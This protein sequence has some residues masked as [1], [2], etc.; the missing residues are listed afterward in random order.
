MK[1]IYFILF[2]IFSINLTFGQATTPFTCDGNGYLFLNGPADVY[3]VNLQTGAAT[4]VK[5]DIIPNQISV[6]YNPVDNYIWGVDK[7][8]KQLVKIDKNWNKTLYNTNLPTQIH[9]ADIDKNGIF[10][11]YTGTQIYRYNLNTTP[12]TQLS[13]LSTTSISVSDFAFNPLDGF[14]YGVTGAGQIYKINPANG[15]TTLVRTISGLVNQTY[16]AAYFDA[17][18]TLYLS[19]NTNGKVYKISN[20]ALTNPSSTESAVFFSNGPTASAND[21]ARCAFAPLCKVGAVAP[22][23]SQSSITNTCTS[24]SVSLAGISASNTPDGTSL[25]WHSG[26]PTTTA[27]KLSNLTITT[28]GTYYATFFDATNNCYSASNTPFVVT[29]NPVPTTPTSVAASSTSICSGASVNLTG[30]CSVGTLTWY[31][32]SPSGTLAGTGSPKAVTLT[33]TKT[34]VATCKTTSPACES[35]PS[36]PITITV[37]PKPNPPTIVAGS[38]RI[39]SGTSTTLTAQDCA[40]TVNWSTGATGPSI[41]VSPTIATSY[42]A[43]CT[44]AAGCVSNASTS[45]INITIATVY[46]SVDRLNV[47]SGESVT[48][49]MGGCAT[50]RD[51]YGNAVLISSSG[52]SNTFVNSPLTNTTYTAKCGAT[53]ATSCATNSTTGVAVTVR[54]TPSAPTTSGTTTICLGSSATLT[55][56]GCTGTVNWSDSQTG[57]SIT[58][59]PNSTTSYTATCNTNGC[60]SPVS[61]PVIVTVE[62]IPT[63]PTGLNPVTICLNES[64]NLGG[65]C[66]ANNLRWYSNVGLTI[67]ETMPVAPTSTKTYYAICRSTNCQSAAIPVVVTVNPIPT[68]PTSLVANPATICQGKS[69]VMSGTCAV[70]SNLVWYSDLGLTSVLVSSTVSPNST[71]TYYASCEKSGCKSPASQITINVNPSPTDPTSLTSSTSICTG[72]SINLTGTCPSGSTIQWYQGVVDASSLKGTGSPFAVSPTETTTYV[73]TCKSNSN[74]C[75]SPSSANI[76]INLT[77]TPTT[78]TGVSVSKSQICSGESVTL[79]GTCSTGTIKWYINAGLTNEVSSPDSP[80]AT[81]T[82]YGSCVIGACKSPSSNVTVSV[83]ATPSIPTSLGATNPIICAGQ[84]STLSGS[85]TSGTLTWYSNIGLTSSVGSTVQPNSTSTYYASCVN[86][87]CKSPAASIEI[88]VVSI[89]NAP[90]STSNSPSNVCSGQTVSLNG[91]CS[92]TDGIHW[93][94][95]SILTTEITPS[96]LTPNSTTTY[97]AVC[98]NS[99]C[100]SSTTSH[101]VQVNALPAAPE[102]VPSSRNLC[103]GS[104]I[105]MTAS[106]C[107]GTVNWTINGVAGPSTA[108]IIQT[109]T[110]TSTYTAT[111]TNTATNCVSPASGASVVTV[112][113]PPPTPSISISKNVICEGESIVLTS[114]NCTGIT[115]WFRTGDITSLSTSNPLTVTPAS[116]GSYYA[117]CSTSGTVIQCES[118]SSDPLPVTVNPLPIAPVIST[119]DNS[120]CAGESTDLTAASCAGTVN[121]SNGQTGST[122]TVSPASTTLYTAKCMVSNCEGPVSNQITITVTNIPTAPTS[123]SATSICSGQFSTLSGTCAS[124]TI[125]WFSDAA[126][127]IT[128]SSSVNPSTTKTYYAKCVDV[129]CSGPSSSVVVTVVQTPTAPSGTSSNPAAICSGS[130]AE[131]LGACATG[132]LKWYPDNTLNTAL[133]SNIVAP[134]SSTSYFASCENGSCK[135][136][137]T[138]QIVNVNAI[139]AVPILTAGANS[140]CATASTVLTAS[141]CV[142]TVIWSTLD[143][144]STLTVSPNSNTTY[145]ATCTDA[146]GCISPSSASLNITVI[147]TPEAPTITP[148]NSEI[149]PGETVNLSASGC[150][151]T[152]NW[153]NSTSPTTIVSTG[154][155]LSVTPAISSGYFTKCTTTLGSCVSSESE[156]AVVTVKAIPTITDILTP[157]CTD[158]SKSLLAFQTSGGATSSVSSTNGLT[159]TFDSDGR[160]TLS[161]QDSRQVWVIENIP[162]TTSF[163]VTVI[164]NGCQLTKNYSSTDC[165]TASVF[166]VD[167]LWFKGMAQSENIKLD[168]YVSNEVNID[169]FE[170]ERSINAIDFSK[171]GTTKA[172]NGSENHLYTYVDFSPFSGINYYRLKNIEFDGKSKYSKTIAVNFTERFDFQWNIFPNPVSKDQTGITLKTNNQA[173]IKEINIS[174]IQGIRLM[175]NVSKISEN[176]HFVNFGKLN[177]GVYLMQIITTK[178][179]DTKKFIIQK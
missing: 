94:S 1:K 63:T 16:G 125:Q 120:I 25:T 179:T 127:T 38:T 169:K 130:T 66:G 158:N 140:I 8:T 9:V 139:P 177:P 118:G 53:N 148:G 29:I 52:S 167:I 60:I 32:N 45:T 21:G 122:L 132:I 88:N 178:G 64:V 145:T 19:G 47:C 42:T 146:N 109:P 50:T 36:S 160:E 110:I 135:S 175:S 77:S 104:T 70:G 91:T 149:C 111:C 57:S 107:A 117:T 166:P 87:A 168:W 37:N 71:T 17:N 68:S 134:S 155:S 39:C 76:I 4:L 142:G 20:T 22:T 74:S 173:E 40:G 99:N 100:S 153:Y 119:T 129:N 49:T 170:I 58:V 126:L 56:T 98:K 172:T 26:N 73:A 12:P 44:N 51:F 67:L 112:V 106:G 152:I 65:S 61:L 176:Q 62:T 165:S 156:S 33:A 137:A 150:A 14:I 83:T 113:T 105:T 72:G 159:A 15:S 116:S 102:I 24:S 82:Y 108:S 3:S 23:L 163:T 92:G 81:T 10:Y 141:G 86:G 174:N 28:S 124:G 143:V 54:T 59:T 154:S 171:I 69:T 89:P 138:S 131:L 96:G 133:S 7:V 31:E 79:S 95:N 55:A 136:S 75:E 2:T 13:T 128:E 85:C 97:Y 101:V 34:Y 164:E 121:W 6:G 103:L 161:G 5:N 151:G 157:T 27:N 93:Y 162:N 84:S 114:I 18:G 46:F 35:T 144:G 147:D 43:T 78:P 80:N 11:G 115:N 90:T 48:L 123:L 30:S 41:T